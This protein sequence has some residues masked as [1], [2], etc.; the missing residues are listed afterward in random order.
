[1]DFRMTELSAAVILAQ[2]KRIDAMRAKM[3]R[4]KAV[5]KAAI[6]GIP[7][8]EFR[9][10]PDPE[11][12]LGSLLVFFLPD[13]EITARVTRDLGCNDLSKSG[14]HVY[15]N[16]EQLLDKRTVSPE[17]CPFTCPYYESEEPSYRRGML[18]QTDALLQRAVNISVGVWDKGL[19][20]AFGV[21][22][23]SS[24][25]EV[26]RQAETLSSI[27]CKHLK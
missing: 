23:R 17:R 8:V 20:A 1:M 13:A 25:D 27:L 10:L 19:G 12:D 9:D 7:G 18:P 3:H 16:M 6:T 22:I 11:G 2:M 15:S 14:W 26:K 21:K 5:L 24:D 4:D